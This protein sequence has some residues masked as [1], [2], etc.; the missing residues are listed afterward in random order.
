MIDFPNELKFQLGEKKW[1]K[2]SNKEKLFEIGFCLTRTWA[3]RQVAERSDYNY[4][5]SE[6]GKLLKL[7]KDIEHKMLIERKMA[8]YEVD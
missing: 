1:S 5:T 8:G 4:Y 2:L 7:K 3:N 6:T